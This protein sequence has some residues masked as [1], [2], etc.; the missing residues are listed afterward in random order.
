METKE[1]KSW[2]DIRTQAAIEAMKTIIN[3][4][5]TAGHFMEKDFVVARMAVD[6]ANALVYE[7][8]NKGFN[9]EYYR[10]CSNGY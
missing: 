2:E 10:T 9:E 6:Y 8:K 3:V 1:K 4:T 7:L 5:G